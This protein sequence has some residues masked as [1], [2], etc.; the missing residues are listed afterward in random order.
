MTPVTIRASSLATLQDCPARFEAIHI[1]KKSSPSSSKALLGTAIH[2]STAKYDASVL[3]GEGIT[4][5]EAAAAAVDA[6]RKPDH[7]VAFEDD[8]DL[9]QMEDVAI[10]LHTRYC[11]EIAPTQQYV[12]VE[13]TCAK[14]EITDLGL[15][16]TGTTDR[17]ARHG[18]D[19]GIRDLKSGG[20][21]VKAD[22][23]VKTQGHASQIGIY[24]L[25]AEHGSG[26]PIRA[27]ARIVGLQTGKT[28]RGQ[29][30]AV[31]G[32][33][34][35]AKQMLI[36]D[37][38]APGLLEVASRIIHR[39]DFMGNPGSNLCSGKFCPVFN[40]CRWRK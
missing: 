28:A 7:D 35:G 13:V 31:S 33:I 25:L 22:G 15:I 18:E 27:P 32:D 36:G 12:A 38:D 14:V 29:R 26:L 5:D 21:A 17:V 30:V 10:A 23:T 19:F 37:A 11:T 6:I 8:D 40:T 20:T 2:A 34:V 3:R 1:L 9:Q 24:E 39:G 16:L 4:V